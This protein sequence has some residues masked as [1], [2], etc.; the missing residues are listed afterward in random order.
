MIRT[1][2]LRLGLAAASMAVCGLMIFWFTHERSSSDA[3]VRQAFELQRRGEAAHA[4][5]TLD[6]ALQR[7]PSD[8]RLLLAR[9]QFA[10]DDGEMS[11]ALELLG[12]VPEQS[13]SLAGYARLA[14]ATILL[15]QNLL[16]EAEVQFVDAQKLLDDPAPALEEL[17]YLHWLRMKK[18][19][20]KQVLE[21]LSKARPWTL[22]ELVMYL[23]AGRTGAPVEEHMRQLEQA[24]AA[25]PNDGPSAIALAQYW[26]F[27]L[28]PDDAVSKMSALWSSHRQPAGFAAIYAETL[29]RE[30]QLDK[31]QSIL[32]GDDDSTSRLTARARGTI[33][34]A[35]DDPRGA[36]VHLKQAFIQD[37]NDPDANY[38]LS[39]ASARLGREDLAKTFAK[40]SLDLRELSRELF[41]LQHAAKE[42]TNE[43]VTHLATVARRLDQLGRLDD[44]KKLT[45]W[46]S[47]SGLARRFGKFEPEPVSDDTMSPAS[48][49]RELDNV[50]GEGQ[51]VATA[52]STRL[53]ASD[54]TDQ[55]PFLDVAAEAGLDFHYNHGRSAEMYIIE[56]IG[57]GVAVLDYD[58]N[59][60]PDLFFAQGAYPS[61]EQAAKAA[62]KPTNCLFANHGGRFLEVT[63]SAAVTDTAYTTGAAAADF[64]N[65]GFEDLFITNVGRNQLLRNNGD[66]TFQDVTDIAGIIE[67]GNS[68][69][70]ALADFDRDGDLDLYVANYIS[71]MPVCRDREGNPVVCHPRD[72]TAQSNFLYENLGDGTFRDVTGLANADAEDGKSLGV[73]VADFDHDLWPDIYVSNDT[74]P[75]FLFHNVSGVS[76][77]LRFEEVGL[78]SGTAVDRN[79]LAQAGMGIAVDDFDRNGATDLYVTNFYADVNT[80]YRNRGNLVFSDDTIEVGLAQPTRQLLGFGT[81]GVDADRDG[82]PDLLI[83][84]GHIA[85]NRKHG[86]PYKMRSQFFWNRGGT[87]V[88]Q[89]DGSGGFFDLENLG[90]GLSLVDHNRDGRVD[91]VASF[92]DRPAALLENRLSAPTHGLTIEF[93]GRLS[94]RDASNVRVDVKYAGQTAFAELWTGGYLGTNEKKVHFGLGDATHV[95]EL[96]I[97]WPSG[98]KEFRE[99]V[100]AGPPLLFV[101]PLPGA[102]SVQ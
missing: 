21:D 47:R 94:V 45:N 80:M 98:Q 83:L 86:E 6:D 68:S 16:K 19:Q 89:R 99:S 102:E 31:A 96:T 22:E 57:G 71:P 54:A 56:T 53:A 35:Q 81:Q 30:G 64:D 42:R 58:H 46:Y 26:A 85:D 69:S 18:Q 17:A 10:A 28:D 7:Q 65:D 24:V 55:L 32:A 66:G 3:I 73:V 14:A 59:G 74:T 51:R 78:Q 36:V 41:G 61:P 5:R 4:R 43:F 8:A 20:A 87:F 67:E 91:L 52:P 49:L 92:L 75:N 25:D 77:G 62:D 44:R 40:R 93:V 72:L 90:R 15:R 12:R 76:K 9:A 37:S 29:L 27:A 70:A 84:N 1:L 39:V 100:P 33:R 50:T 95:D 34:L 79:G 48:L 13:G 2:V 63:R 88:E 60:W 38:Q 101:E 82:W 11:R 23:L 97:T